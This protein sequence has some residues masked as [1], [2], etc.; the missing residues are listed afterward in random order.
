MGVRF[1]VGSY[2]V[3]VVSFPAE[4]TEQDIHAWYDSVER[5][6]EEAESPIAFIDDL[7]AV[8]FAKTTSAQRRTA[9]RR[10]DQLMRRFASMHAGN[11]RIVGGPIAIAVLRAFDWLSPAPWPVASFRDEASAVA[12]CSARIAERRAHGPTMRSASD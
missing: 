9:A 2:P 3:I 5:Y 8:E 6:L 1:D 7:R 4:G 11:A 12:W 10:H